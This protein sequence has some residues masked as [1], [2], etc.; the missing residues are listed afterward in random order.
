MRLATSLTTALATAVLGTPVAVG[1]SSP[2]AAVGDNVCALTAPHHLQVTLPRR[3]DVTIDRDHGRVRVSDH[4]CS[5]DGHPVRVAD[6]AALAVRVVRSPEVTGETVRLPD[7]VAWR[8][9][10][11]AATSGRVRVRVDLGRTD[12]RHDDRT[13]HKFDRV[14]VGG[15]PRADAWHVVQDDRGSSVSF[16]ES[17]DREVAVGGAILRLA[18]G[19]GDDTVDLDAGDGGYPTDNQPAEVSTGRGA[20]VV[21]TAS[22]ELHR[23]DLGAGPDVVEITERD[24]KGAGDAFVRPGYGDDAVTVTSPARVGIDAERTSDGRDTLT[25][26]PL[27]D[28][29]DP[30]TT[31]DP[32]QV[33]WSYRRRTTPVSV[34]TDG[35]ADDGAPGEGD[36]VPT[37]TISVSG[38]HA[39]DTIDTR[40][41]TAAG[42]QSYHSIFGNGGADDITTSPWLD[43]VQAGAG[44]DHVTVVGTAAQTSLDG[45]D[46]VYADA[47]AD[48]VVGSA[49][50][51]S[52]DGGPGDDLVQGHGGDDSLTGGRGD[53]VLHGGDGDDQLG[54]STSYNPPGSTRGDLDVAFG[55]AGDDYFGYPTT[56]HDRL[57]VVGGAGDDLFSVRNGLRDRVRGGAGDDEAYA[58]A[59]D[60]LRSIETRH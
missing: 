56:D 15:T 33:S 44:D 19:D 53:D 12:Y 36:D 7:V 9:D 29:Y 49:A 30:T 1:L 2:A 52:V 39:D 42:P 54:D 31:T 50:A 34:T 6:L 41:S 51:E 28:G 27:P 43:A 38:G 37:R 35:V 23:A 57:T 16:D 5:A 3:V 20:D 18:T 26:P 11:A 58:D 8:S 60:V 59:Q 17:A 13:T 47:G 46:T 55:G 32:V 24:G 14:V 22:V 25:L 21:H 10:Q 45:A 40:R 48:V 4:T